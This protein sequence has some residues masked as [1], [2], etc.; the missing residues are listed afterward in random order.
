MKH[1]KT[2]PK[3]HAKTRFWDRFSPPKPLQNRS[4]I[5][6]AKRC[7]KKHLQDPLKITCLSKEREAR[8]Y[9]RVVGACN[10]QSE[11]LK[12]GWTAENSPNQHKT[13]KILKNREK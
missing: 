7:K 13:I 11:D 9:M 10:P 12:I 3:R 2:Q 5:D 1:Q 8:R 6:V 4:E